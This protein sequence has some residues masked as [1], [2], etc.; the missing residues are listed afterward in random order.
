MIF[1]CIIEKNTGILLF[2]W[3]ENKDVEGQEYDRTIG[4]YWV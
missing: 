4:H 3:E 2:K 1:T